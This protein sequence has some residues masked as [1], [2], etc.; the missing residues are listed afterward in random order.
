MLKISQHNIIEQERGGMRSVWPSS[1]SSRSVA[2]YHYRRQKQRC[3]G[4]SRK[5]VWGTGQ[6]RHS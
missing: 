2:M 5:K 1:K 6:K 4:D 3:G